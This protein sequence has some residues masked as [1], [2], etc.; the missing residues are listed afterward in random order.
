[1]PSKAPQQEPGTSSLAGALESIE[2][3]VRALV[4]IAELRVWL[5]CRGDVVAER[6][7][8]QAAAALAADGRDPAGWSVHVARPEQD[9]TRRRVRFAGVEVVQ[10]GPGYSTARVTLEWEGRVYTGEASGET[11]LPIEFRSVA[12]AALLALQKL[13]EGAHGVRLVGV[14]QIRAFD[15]DLLVVALYRQGAPPQKLVGTVLMNPDPHRAAAVAVLNALNR[16]LGNF[17]AV[18]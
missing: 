2:G 14:K 11:G 1:M 13:T 10:A 9:D 6:V 18:P 8:E 5:V 7:R 17:L 3:V 12:A 16:V 15:A 4:A